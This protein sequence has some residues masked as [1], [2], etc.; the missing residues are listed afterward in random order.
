MFE[1]IEI[2][3]SVVTDSHA[4]TDNFIMKNG[5][6]YLKAKFEKIELRKYAN[7]LLCNKF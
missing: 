7:N 4:L 3:R 1:M 2:I 5:F 6:D